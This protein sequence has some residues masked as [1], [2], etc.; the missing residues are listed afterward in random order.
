MDLEK[1][2]PKE[3]IELY[4]N[5]ED[6]IRKKIKL[7]TGNFTGELG[8]YYVQDFYNREKPL[9]K[10]KLSKTGNPNFDAKDKNG[11]TYS[12]KT[13]TGKST[14]C[15]TGLELNSKNEIVKKEFDFLIIVVLSKKY[16]LKEII[17]IEW[18]VFQERKLW[19]KTEKKYQMNV[20]IKL[21][22]QSNVLYLNNTN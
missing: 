15:F 2:T 5:I 21:R 12:I 13:V 8:E 14:S 19:H 6:E 1:Y 3:L 16:K 17:E 22:K 10:L 11:I 7:R 18:D 20:S 4:S 9:L